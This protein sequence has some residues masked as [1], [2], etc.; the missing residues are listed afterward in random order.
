MV[1]APVDPVD[2]HPHH[3]PLSLEV[4]SS[5]VDD[6]NLALPHMQ[7]A[8]RRSGPEAQPT[9]VMLRDHPG[10]SV[11]SMRMGYSK[12]GFVDTDADVV[13]MVAARDAP[14]GSRWDGVDLSS[15]DTWLY[16]GGGH[17]QAVDRPG[18]EVAMV[19]IDERD[20]TQALDD[21]GRYL[22]P[23]KQG[24]IRDDHAR[25]FVRA[26]DRNAAS[27]DVT[28]L[29]ATVARA[30]SDIRPGPTS[31]SG[32]RIRSEAVVRR[33]V[34]YSQDTGD[35]L[36]SSL[37]LCR[38]AG[39]SERRLQTAFRDVYDMSPSEFFRTRALSEARSRLID[40]SQWRARVTTVAYEL[41]FHH[42]G[43]FAAAFKAQHG[44]YPSEVPMS[45]SVFERDS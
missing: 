11:V 15:G 24:K 17:H 25:A 32:R 18:M 39:V 13:T 14:P 42:L 5:E 19:V 7:A 16:P 35:W 44:W 30:V 21:L 41:G 4:R 27:S 37:A 10:V 3:E 22:T 8:L 1:S 38:A 36:P 43:R 45:E 9:N 29:V 33:A 31:A 20:L 28:E 6:F 12:V 2:A 26:F 34:D 40:R 23:M